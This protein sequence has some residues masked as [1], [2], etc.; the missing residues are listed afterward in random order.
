MLMVPFGIDFGRVF[1]GWVTL[2]NAV[3]EPAKF[4]AINPDDWQGTVNAAAQAEQDPTTSPAIN[5]APNFGCPNAS[6]PDRPSNRVVSAQGRAVLNAMRANA[7][8]ATVHPRRSRELLDQAF[9]GQVVEL[10]RIVWHYQARTAVDDEC[11][12]DHLDGR[13]ILACSGASSGR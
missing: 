5:T 3:R 9:L 2:S 4:A 8:W 12:S 10:T 1:M 13:A 6:V 7:M 11:P